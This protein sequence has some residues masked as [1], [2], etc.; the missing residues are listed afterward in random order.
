MFRH[1]RLDVPQRPASAVLNEPFTLQP[2]G[3]SGD[4]D[5]WQ[6]TVDALCTL[7]DGVCDFNC[8][9]TFEQG[10]G[11]RCKP[12]MDCCTEIPTSC[13]MATESTPV[14]FAAD[15]TIASVEVTTPAKHVITTPEPRLA[16]RTS[17]TDPPTR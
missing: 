16:E 5:I 8:N 1:K 2:H 11:T 9:C 14:V 15:F 4:D 13:L 7:P 12:T 6:W 17:R 3:L 10:A